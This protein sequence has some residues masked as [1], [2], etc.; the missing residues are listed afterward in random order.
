MRSAYSAARS[1][2]DRLDSRS[3]DL[4]VAAAAGDENAR[5][6]D[7]DLR[8]RIEA[9]LSDLYGLEAEAATASE[10]T[11]LRETADALNAL[12]RTID[13]AARESA[14]DEALGAVGPARD[15]LDTA[16]DG[17]AA[18]IRRIGVIGTPERARVSRHLPVR[19]P[20]FTSLTCRS[21]IRVVPAAGDLA[22]LACGA[23]GTVM[24][25]M[26]YAAES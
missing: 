25:E 26:G 14:P 22:S 5:A 23:A 1:V 10:R 4:R 16:L 7:R 18:Q 12:D 19:D 17:L 21:M 9:A 13:E 2:L 24:A 6:A 20:I 15:R 8:R 3:V 11:V